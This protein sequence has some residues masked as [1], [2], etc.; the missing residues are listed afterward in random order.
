M[1]INWT[2]PWR[3]RGRLGARRADA[4]QKVPV[5]STGLGYTSEKEVYSLF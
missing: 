5:G 3:R 2:G 4:V 1:E